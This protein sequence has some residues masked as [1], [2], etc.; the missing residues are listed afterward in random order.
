MEDLEMYLNSIDRY[1]R[2]LY[3]NNSK[4]LRCIYLCQYSIVS[5]TTHTHTSYPSANIHYVY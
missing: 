1:P 3:N 4:A 5:N 2:L